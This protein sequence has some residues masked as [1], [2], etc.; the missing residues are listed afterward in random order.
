MLMVSTLWALPVLRPVILTRREGD[1]VQ[2]V[3]VSVLTTLSLTSHVPPG[4]SY[5]HQR[6]DP[7]LKSRLETQKTGG[8]EE[9]ATSPGE[10]W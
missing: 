4:A 5:N 1:K 10:I 8:E 6:P 3:T 9:E 2:P 7:G